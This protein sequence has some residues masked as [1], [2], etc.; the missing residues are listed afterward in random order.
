MLN[1]A[2]PHTCDV[3]FGTNTVASGERQFVMTALHDV[4][5]GEQV[6]ESPNATY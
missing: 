4:A 6:R 2:L 3:D 1:T 5:A